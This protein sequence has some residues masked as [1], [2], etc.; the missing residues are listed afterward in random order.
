MSEIRTV[1]T[2][3]SKWDE[4][5]FS[6][7]LYEDR[8]KQ[9]RADLAHVNAAIKIFEAS[10]DPKEMGRYVDAHRLMK[11]GEPIDLCKE[12]LASGPKSTPEL[13]LHIMQAKGLDTGNRVLAKAITAQLIHSLRMQ[14]PRGRIVKDG[15]KGTAQV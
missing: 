14:A 5:Q 13:A 6:I 1:T 10:G 11:R 15:K 9:A 8:I 7:R 12:A 3:K 4:I 2:L